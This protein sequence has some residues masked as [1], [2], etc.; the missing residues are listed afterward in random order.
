MDNGL[1][2]I[3]CYF[4]SVFRGLRIE[5]LI[6]KYHDLLENSKEFLNVSDDII[7]SLIIL[8]EYILNSNLW[9]YVISKDLKVNNIDDLYK[10]AISYEK[11]FKEDIT[12]T[13]SAIVLYKLAFII[14]SSEEE[15]ISKIISTLS[16]IIDDKYLTDDKD[17]NNYNYCL[18]IIDNMYKEHQ[19]ASMSYQYALNLVNK[20]FKFYQN[21]HSLV[22]VD[23][24]SFQY[25]KK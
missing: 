18:N 9:E 23:K 21:D 8:N 10:I 11:K 5:E 20:L 25:Y 4:E 15:D 6:K 14:N 13:K 3:G 19:L 17:F 12:D 7:S 22:G 16:S 24:E 1:K 2:I